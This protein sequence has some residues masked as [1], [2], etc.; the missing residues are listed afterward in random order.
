MTKASHPTSLLGHD[1]EKV[2]TGEADLIKSRK[3]PYI[4]QTRFSRM[5]RCNSGLLKQVGRI[6]QQP[7]HHTQPSPHPKSR[8]PPPPTPTTPPPPPPPPPCEGQTNGIEETGL[9]FFLHAVTWT[10]RPGNAVSNLSLHRWGKV[11]STGMAAKRGPPPRTMQHDVLGS[12]GHDHSMLAEAVWE[13][14]NPI[15]A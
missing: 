15:T 5:A 3:R 9:C 12:P 11:V 2:S 7:P 6:P 8:T 10:G 13:R 1:H 4:Q 14:T